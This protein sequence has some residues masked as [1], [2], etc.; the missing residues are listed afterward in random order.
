MCQNTTMR[1]NGAW[2]KS[3]MFKKHITPCTVV[4]TSL[5]V[6]DK[7]LE[8]PA[9]VKRVYSGVLNCAFSFLKTVR[10][11]TKYDHS[12]LAF[13]LHVGIRLY[14]TSTPDRG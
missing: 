13:V 8:A 2:I 11:K 1:V 12:V 3:F 9:S 5:L 10:S 6:R 7:A 4:I 14:P